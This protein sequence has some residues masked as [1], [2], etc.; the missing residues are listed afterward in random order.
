MGVRRD[1]NET[2]T[3]L[4]S[5]GLPGRLIIVGKLQDRSVICILQFEAFPAVTERGAI[6]ESARHRMVGSI[7][8]LKGGEIARDQNSLTRGQ[9]DDGTASEIKFNSLREANL[10]QIQRVRTADV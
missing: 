9:R 1:Q 2:V 7:S 6:D 8:G 5:L 10:L 3:G 4:V